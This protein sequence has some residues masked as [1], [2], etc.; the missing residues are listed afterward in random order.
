MLAAFRMPTH[1]AP[2]L[3]AR[4]NSILVFFLIC[5]VLA[6][7]MAANVL[8][9]IV[10]FGDSITQGGWQPHGFAQRLAYV[11]ARKL[12]VTNRGLSGYNTE[13]AIP[14]FEQA[15]TSRVCTYT[16]DHLNRLLFCPC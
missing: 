16:R 13:W 5:L 10:L 1:L 8:D 14:V 2:W 12:D 4:L 6:I 7:P 3:C 9:T 15:R 11:Y